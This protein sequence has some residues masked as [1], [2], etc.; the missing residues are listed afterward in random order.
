[1]GDGVDPDRDLT[2]EQAIPRYVENEKA[3]VA[4]LIGRHLGSEGATE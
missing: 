4:A 2:G 1:M 3:T